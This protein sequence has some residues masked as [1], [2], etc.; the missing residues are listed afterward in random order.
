MLSSTY[1]CL[2]LLAR[3]AFFEL[4]NLGAALPP[5]E[6]LQIANL[7]LILFLLVVCEFDPN[8]WL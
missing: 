1:K 2:G 6:S 8:A 4:K 3:L 5:S 7:L